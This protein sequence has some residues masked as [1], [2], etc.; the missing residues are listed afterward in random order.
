MKIKV[1]EARMSKVFKVGLVKI[2]LGEPFAFKEMGTISVPV[3]IGIPMPGDY[4]EYETYAERDTLTGGG[5]ETRIVERI[6]RMVGDILDEA[7]L[8][9]IGGKKYKLSMFASWEDSMLADKA[10]M[11]AVKAEITRR[12]DAFKGE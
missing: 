7:S 6:R 4:R 5:L 2:R 11:D 8:D 1:N 9:D 12:L 3:R 10:G